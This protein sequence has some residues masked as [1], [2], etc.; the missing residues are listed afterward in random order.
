MGGYLFLQSIP[1]A[2]VQV[3]HKRSNR[4]GALEHPGAASLEAK[5]SAVYQSNV[6]LDS[7]CIWFQHAL[8]FGA[9]D[10][11]AIAGTAVGSGETRHES[12]KQ[13][14]DEL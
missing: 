14:F 13:V 4:S 3:N 8:N 6:P 7:L 10:D 1:G 2:R 12:V 9:L 5:L 11:R